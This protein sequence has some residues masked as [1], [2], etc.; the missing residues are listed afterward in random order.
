MTPYALYEAFPKSLVTL[1][2]GRVATGAALCGFVGISSAII[3]RYDAIRYTHEDF[4][5]I[6]FFDR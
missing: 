5:R 6:K 4:D 2:L 3:V 1:W